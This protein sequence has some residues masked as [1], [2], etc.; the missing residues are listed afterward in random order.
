MV[1]KFKYS[2]EHI[3]D[4]NIFLLKVN[5]NIESINRN[6]IPDSELLD[7][8]LYKFEHDRNKRLLARSFL[9]AYL[10]SEYQIENFELGYNQYKKP[11]LKHNKNIDFSISYSKDYI[12]IAISDK[13]KIGVDI[14]YIDKD[15][16]HNE[17]KEIIMH[18]NEIAHYN[19]I[20]KEED[21]LDFFFEVFNTK[22]SIIKSMGMGLYFDIRNLNTLDASS[23]FLSINIYKKLNLLFKCMLVLNQNTQK[24]MYE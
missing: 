19:Q 17:L 24:L 18:S 2:R 1:D 14:E 22:E 10:K 6:I 21:K 15:I 3:K 4:T 16:N 7:I 11:Y 13:H 8:Q 9:Y 23:S 20:Q 12:L 5:D